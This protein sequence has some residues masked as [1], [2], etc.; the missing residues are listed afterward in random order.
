MKVNVAFWIALVAGLS[1]VPSR[2]L[3]SESDTGAIER[4][5]VQSSTIASAGYAPKARLLEI[6]FRSGAIY[7]YRDVPETVFSA[8]SKAHSKGRYFGTDIRG[9]FPYE[10]LKKA[11]R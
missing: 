11:N 2:N 7:R 5:A 9:K 1:A 6:E 4:L 3:L 10:K 8:F